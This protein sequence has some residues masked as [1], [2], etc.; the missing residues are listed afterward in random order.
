MVDGQTLDVQYGYGISGAGNAKNFRGNSVTYPNA[1]EP[2]ASQRWER[3]TLWDLGCRTGPK[4]AE[5]DEKERVGSLG[6][7]ASTAPTDTQV[8]LRF[9]PGPGRGWVSFR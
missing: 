1:R 9:Q 7:G 4:G 2:T 3:E 5:K 8:A 6:G